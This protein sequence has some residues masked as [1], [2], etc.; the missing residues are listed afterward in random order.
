[1]DSAKAKLAQDWWHE[2]ERLSSVLGRV[3]PDE[4]CCDGLSQRQCAVLRVLTARQGARLSELATHCGITPSAMSRV[5][6]RLEQRA[7]VQRVWGNPQDGRS[8]SVAITEAG[9]T[10][11]RQLDALMLE[12][13]ARLAAA[14]PDAQREQVLDAL[15]LLNRAMESAPCCGLNDPVARL[16]ESE[17]PPAD[18]NTKHEALSVDTVSVGSVSVEEKA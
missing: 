18:A 9:L 14:I 1:M 6:D 17:R 10:V 11:R 13:S 15:R 16:P 4:V 8:A 3:G 2:L 12:R 7:L 5:L